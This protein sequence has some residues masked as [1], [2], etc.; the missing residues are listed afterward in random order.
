MRKIFIF[1]SFVLV[2]TIAFAQTDYNKQAWELYIKL[3]SMTVQLHEKGTVWTEKF[4]ELY[5]IN[6]NYNELSPLRQDIEHLID[7]GLIEMNK[8][9][10]KIPG[11]NNLRVAYIKLFNLEKTMVVKAYVPFEHLSNY[12]AP[13]TISNYYKY[14]SIY[15]KKEDEE[16]H[17]VDIAKMQY[18]KKNKLK[19]ETPDTQ[20]NK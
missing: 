4:N 14:L 9:K 1:L 20:P 13:E 18:A 11:S 19:L 16:L 10:D 3:E 6:K 12:S 7:S 15:D 2:Q 5:K 8:M 17:N